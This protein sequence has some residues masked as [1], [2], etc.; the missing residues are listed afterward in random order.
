MTA[1]IAGPAEQYTLAQR[2][3]SAKNY[4]YE[5]T[6]SDYSM[7]SINRATE[8]L[9]AVRAEVEASP[10]SEDDLIYTYNGPYGVGLAIRL[11]LTV[12]ELTRKAGDP[13][14]TQDSRDHYARQLITFAEKLA[15]FEAEHEWD[16]HAKPG[17][18]RGECDR[19]GV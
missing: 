13:T 17:T 5:A 12:A 3:L 10:W 11:E 6:M 8:Q 1:T 9:R 15:K 14:S 19:H 2:L 18:C 7:D 4:A 16:G